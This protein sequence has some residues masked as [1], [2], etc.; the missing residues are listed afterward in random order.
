MLCCTVKLRTPSCV[1]AS[2]LF[3]LTIAVCLFQRKRNFF[4]KK[5]FSYHKSYPSWRGTQI[6]SYARESLPHRMTEFCWVSNLKF[7]GEPLFNCLQNLQQQTFTYKHTHTHTRL[8]S[9]LDFG[10][11]RTELY[12]TR[13]KCKMFLELFQILFEPEFFSEIVHECL[14]NF[15][16]VRIRTFPEYIVP[17]KTKKIV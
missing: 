11:E 1:Y 15:V 14:F 16:K 5:W 8:I 4:Q 3:N 2:I 17:L 10:F 13:K 6:F 7:I 12:T 9:S